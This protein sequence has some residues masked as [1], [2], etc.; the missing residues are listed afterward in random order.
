MKPTID[1]L[2]AGDESMGNDKGYEVASLEEAEEFAKRRNEDYDVVI[3]TL[4][5]KIDALWKMTKSNMDN[6]MMN[7][8]DDIR[9]EQISQ[10]EKAIAMWQSVSSQR[11]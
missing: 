5:K 3:D 8:M 4:Q 6:D 10:L 1:N 11:D 2:L 9:L 7:I